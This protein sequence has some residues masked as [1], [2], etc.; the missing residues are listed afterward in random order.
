MNLAEMKMYK[1]KEINTNHKNLAKPKI[2]ITLAEVS[3]NLKKMS[4]LKKKLG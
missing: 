2:R 1:K 4:K 3:P